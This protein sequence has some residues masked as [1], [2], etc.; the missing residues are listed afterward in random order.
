MPSH[1]DIC[2]LFSLQY[3]TGMQVSTLSISMGTSLFSPLFPFSV[4]PFE[5]VDRTYANIIELKQPRIPSC[6]QIIRRHFQRHR[7]QSSS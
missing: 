2:Q 5:L 6:Q 1:T 4:F 7:Y 3:T